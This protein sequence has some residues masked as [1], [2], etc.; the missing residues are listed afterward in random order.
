MA[1]D[2][3]YINWYSSANYDRLNVFLPKGSRE[4]IKMEA[5][6]RGQSLNEFIRSLIPERLIAERKF[7]R[8][9]ETENEDSGH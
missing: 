2:S 5:K 7:V 8:K 1:N 6:N 3:K 9:R 4:K